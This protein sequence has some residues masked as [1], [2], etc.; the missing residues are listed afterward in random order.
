LVTILN[1]YYENREDLDKVAGWCYQR[2]QA[3]EY[4]WENIGALVNGIIKR[5]LEE[6]TSGKGFGDD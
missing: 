2:L 5:T 4:K 3:D 6:P 1:H